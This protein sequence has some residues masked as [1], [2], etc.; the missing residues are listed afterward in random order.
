MIFASFVVLHSSFFFFATSQ[1][2]EKGVH[3]IF[4]KVWMPFVIRR[5]TDSW[6]RPRVRF[7]QH[8][9]APRASFMPFFVLW[10]IQSSRVLLPQHTHL[11]KRDPIVKNIMLYIDYN[12]TSFSV[13]PPVMKSWI[14][15]SWII[16]ALHFQ[17]FHYNLMLTSSR[18]FMRLGFIRIHYNTQICIIHWPFDSSIFT[19]CNAKEIQG[20]LNLL[21][22]TR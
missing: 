19:D 21:I 4:Q 20:K 17:V 1:E 13:S 14:F 18:N 7:C 6:S 11:L 3:G 16:S 5:L 22:P 8:K 2:E 15:F 10:S 12:V 9:A